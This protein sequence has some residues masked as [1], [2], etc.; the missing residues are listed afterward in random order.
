MR[1]HPTGSAD[2]SSCGAATA[3]LSAPPG[4]DDRAAI[5]GGTA[6][7]PYRLQLE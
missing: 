5:A 3:P 1:L 6:V 2:R 7:R 4:R